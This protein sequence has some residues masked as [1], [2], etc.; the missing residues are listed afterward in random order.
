MATEIKF[1]WSSTQ[2]DVPATSDLALGE[3]AINTY[4]GRMYTEKNDGS[5]AISEIGSNPASF[6]IN[7][8]ITFPT[9]DGTNGQVMKTNGSGTLSFGDVG[10]SGITIFKYTITSNTTAITG[11]DD[12]GAS[13]SYT[14]GSEQVYLNGVKLVDAGTDYTATNT[15]TVTL[16]ANAISGDVVEIVC[17]LSLIHI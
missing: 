8:A 13:L 1:K 4:H 11:N 16:A 10:G 14:V 17:V 7:D 3:V 2:N 15:T 6:T 5:A 9:S 12:D